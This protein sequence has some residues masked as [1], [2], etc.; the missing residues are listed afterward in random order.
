MET[1]TGV[2]VCVIAPFKT[3][4]QI[5][6][7]YNLKEKKLKIMGVRVA[8]LDAVSIESSFNIPGNKFTTTTGSFYYFLT[9][10]QSPTH[11]YSSGNTMTVQ[12]ASYFNPPSSLE[13]CLVFPNIL[14]LLPYSS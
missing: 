13:L 4:R 6:E 7:V 5:T 11:L 12:L 3:Y 10:E 14:D 1:V 9:L 8:K 2:V